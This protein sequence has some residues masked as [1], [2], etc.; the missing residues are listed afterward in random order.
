M[1]A[2]GM[3]PPGA[4]SEEPARKAE[5]LKGARTWEGVYVALFGWNTSMERCEVPGGRSKPRESSDP[6]VADLD[7]DMD[8][9]SPFGQDVPEEWA[10]HAVNTNEMS[11]QGA[12]GQYP[13]FAVRNSGYQLVEDDSLRQVVGAGQMDGYYPNNYIPP[14]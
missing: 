13:E 3:Q 2:A 5:A 4:R 8:H 7:N 12:W 9:D 6:T 11:P 10:L 14:S 1:G